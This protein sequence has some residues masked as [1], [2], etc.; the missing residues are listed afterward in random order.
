MG[1]NMEA[2]ADWGAAGSSFAPSTA[3]V[4]V[5]VTPGTRGPLLA[6]V[7]MDSEDWRDKEVTDTSVCERTTAGGAKRTEG[8][9]CS[10]SALLLTLA[11]MDEVLPVLAVL[12][13]VVVRL[14][15]VAI[16]AVEADGASVVVQTTLWLVAVVTAA[17]GGREWCGIVSMCAPD[18]LNVV[19][20]VRSPSGVATPFCCALP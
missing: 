3:R 20:G 12:G 8:V 15:V 13:V 6:S 5:L 7:S 4:Y 9:S 18:I 11:S 10:M 1:G 14:V 17:V 16:G 19:V 2:R